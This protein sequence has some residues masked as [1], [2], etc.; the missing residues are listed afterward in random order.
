MRK[1]R[2]IVFYRL[3]DGK[4][5]VEE[6]LDSLPGNV[7]NKIIW[8]LRV[9]RELDRIPDIYFKKLTGTDEIWECR[10]QLGS[11]IYRVLGFFASHSCLILANGFVKKS[12]KTPKS[13]IGSTESYR[14]DFLR[15]CINHG[16]S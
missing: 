16:R 10:I 1:K 14:K 15:R 5:P 9:I 13:E 6:F 2:E 4:C 8:V 7:A 11:N 3:H 12:D